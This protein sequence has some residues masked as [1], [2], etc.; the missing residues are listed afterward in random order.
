[1][2][3][4]G[5]AGCV[6]ANRLSADPDTT[7]PLLGAGG[8]QTLPEI[9]RPQDWPVLR[10][11]SAAWGESIVVQAATGTATPLAR[12]R[13][14]GGSS[15]INVMVFTRGHRDSYDALLGGGHR[16]RPPPRRGRQRRPRRGLR[17][18]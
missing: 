9:R 3:G 13:G 11:S 4:A 14:L 5:T 17:T 15:A 12:G 10:T 18:P 8:E 6:L 2:I 1:M 16:G 7:V